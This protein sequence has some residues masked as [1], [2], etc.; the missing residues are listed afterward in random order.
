VEVVVRVWR[1][2]FIEGRVLGPHGDGAEEM[3]V[4]AFGLE[5]RG[6]ASAR[7]GTEGG[8]RIGP[9]VPG[10]YRLD[11]SHSPD[12]SLAPSE[13]VEALAGDTDVVLR[14][15]AGGSVSGVVVDA[16]TGEP[17]K[18][19]VGLSEAVE[20]PRGY[21]MTSGRSSGEFSFGGLTPGD[22]HLCAASDDGR[23][24]VLRDVPVMAGSKVEGL[25]IPLERGGHVIIRYE[26]PV[27]YANFWIESAGARFGMGGLRSGQQKRVTAPTGEI[28]VR[29]EAYGR[30]DPDSPVAIER[31]RQVTIEAGAEVEVSFEIED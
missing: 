2:V 16:A 18:A 17:V 25:R 9:L 3:L 28:T 22:Y 27:E 26:G 7:S 20:K 30:T 14:V 4:S 8:F 6:R 5:N 13:P 21:R 1:G 29:L 31:E 24:G 11:A 15:T 19:S 12:D 10:R 23:V